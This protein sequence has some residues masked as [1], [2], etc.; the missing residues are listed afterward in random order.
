MSVSMGFIT[1]P[2]H[3]NM[4]DHV[5]VNV[6]RWRWDLLAEAVLH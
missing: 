4:F 1:C 2:V 5:H 3:V 6:A